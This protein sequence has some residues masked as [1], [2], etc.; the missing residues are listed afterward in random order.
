MGPIIAHAG[1][2]SSAALHA[3]VEI[4]TAGGSTARSVRRGGGPASEAALFA[5]SIDVLPPK[6]ELPSRAPLSTRARRPQRNPI[7]HSGGAATR[8]VGET[9]AP[10]KPLSSFIASG[11][12]ARSRAPEN[13]AHEL[14]PGTTVASLRW[15]TVCRALLQQSTAQFDDLAEALVPSASAPALVG[16]LGLFRGDGCTTMASCLAA[17]LAARNGRAMLVDGN[18]T[19]ARLAQLLD[20]VPTLGWQESLANGVPVGDAIVRAVEDRLDLLALSTDRSIDPLALLSGPNS[21]RLA[22]QLRAEYDVV[23]VDLGAFFDPRSQPI[24]LALVSQWNIRSVLAISGNEEA[25][26]RDLETLAEHLEQRGCTL[27]GVAAN[28]FAR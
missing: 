10:K 26:P 2:H 17:R 8:H 4:V 12:A 24:V 16:V 5:T 7:P 22:D 20:A 21:T 13:Q 11:R 6:A 15:P 1:R 28:R 14:R 18:F 23:L 25:D 9:K 19:S 27:A 3:S